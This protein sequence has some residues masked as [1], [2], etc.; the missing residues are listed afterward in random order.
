MGMN[1]G[2][3]QIIEELKSRLVRLISLLESERGEKVALKQGNLDLQKKLK[4][5]QTRI[6]E[7]ELKYANLKIAKSLMAENEDSHDAK[8]RVNRI[9]R[10]IDKCIAL[11]NR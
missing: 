7:L 10:E 2:Q 8:I 3:V 11:L 9:V 5:Q 4:V 6:S 1:A